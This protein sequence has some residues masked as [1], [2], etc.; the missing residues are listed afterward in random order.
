MDIIKQPISEHLS[1]YFF[2]PLKIFLLS[3]TKSQS[4]LI[5]INLLISKNDIY[6]SNNFPFFLTNHQK[7][8]LSELKNRLYLSKK[9]EYFLNEENFN[10]I[11]LNIINEYSNKFNKNLLLKLST[12]NILQTLNYIQTKEQV[13]HELRNIATETY[14]NLQIRDIL[15]LSKKKYTYFA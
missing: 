12:N 15:Y 6:K 2:K 10:Q 1:D 5:N 14:L 3:L 4:M 8:L 7:I 11:L 13:L 9:S